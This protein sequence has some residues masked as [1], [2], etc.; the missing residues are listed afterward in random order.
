MEHPSYGFLGS[1]PSNLGAGLR[2]SV[3]IVL[4]KLNEDLHDIQSVM[5][6][7][8]QDI[9]GQGEKLDNVTNMSET[10]AS[11][12]R[13]YSKKAKEL[14]FQALVQKYAPI[15]AVVGIVVLFLF[16]RW[17]VFGGRRPS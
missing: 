1:C 2:A 12:T 14:A 8:I 3:M 9:L 7:N 4:P 17:M 5:T 16:F 13:K 10:L 6:R 11:E 15:V